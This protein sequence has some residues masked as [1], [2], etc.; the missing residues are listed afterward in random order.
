MAADSLHCSSAESVGF[1][2]KCSLNAAVSGLMA[3]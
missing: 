3:S 2:M 1:E